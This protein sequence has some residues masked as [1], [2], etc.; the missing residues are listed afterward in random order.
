MPP[1]RP[2]PW[3]VCAKESKKR[4]ETLLGKQDKYALNVNE[5]QK[6]HSPTTV[7]EHLSKPLTLTP[8]CPHC[9]DRH[10]AAGAP[11]RRP[12]AELHGERCDKLQAVG[13]KQGQKAREKST[14][15]SI[16][17]S[18]RLCVPGIVFP[19][20]NCTKCVL[21]SGCRRSVSGSS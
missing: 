20:K 5:T 8:C 16:N 4:K 15:R 18:S 10:T 11:R 7:N 9:L 3:C 12:Q 17:F 6:H 21:L 14:D 2:A 19:E 1:P 13:E